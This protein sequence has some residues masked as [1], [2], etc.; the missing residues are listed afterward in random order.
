[1]RVN[2]YCINTV[3]NA[4]STKH[5]REQKYVKNEKDFLRHVEKNL[6][7]LLFSEQG[8]QE[9]LSADQVSARIQ[10]KDPGFY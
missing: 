5:Y 8:V 3:R 6:Y 10:E 7:K 1:M 9:V 4:A 2:R